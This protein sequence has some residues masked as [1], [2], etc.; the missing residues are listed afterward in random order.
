MKTNYEFG[1]KKK[2]KICIMISFFN[3]NNNI[4]FPSICIYV[5]F[6]CLQYCITT[7]IQA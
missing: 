5:I 1:S 7:F 2:K 6:N 4:L 3:Q